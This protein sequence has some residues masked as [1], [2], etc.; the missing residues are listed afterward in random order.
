MNS[1]QIYPNPRMDLFPLLMENQSPEDPARKTILKIVKN[2]T[3]RWIFFKNHPQE[4]LERIGLFS[5]WLNTRKKAS[6]LFSIP[7]PP[8]MPQKSFGRSH[9]CAHTQVWQNYIPVL[10]VGLKCDTYVFPRQH[11]NL[12]HC[13]KL[14]L[15]CGAS[16]S[17]GVQW[18]SNF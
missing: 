2:F 15:T 1:N 4:N 8:P 7:T 12:T 14:G 10:L 16:M 13:T 5:R 6:G 11:L 3:Q 17:R 9:T 18:L